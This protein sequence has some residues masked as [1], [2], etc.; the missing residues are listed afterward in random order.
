M[1]IRSRIGVM[2]RA[3]KVAIATAVVFLSV[4]I[5][6]VAQSQQQQAGDGALGLWSLQP[7]RQHAAPGVKDTSWP[8]TEID[9]FILE[10]LESAGLRPAADADRAVLVR[11]LY[12]DLTGLPPTP[13]QVEA[14]IADTSP[15]ALEKLADR[16]LD[17]PAFGEHWGRHW[18][19]VA[20]F[21]ESVGGGRTKVFD[22]AW[23]YRDYVIASFNSDK[24][25]DR[26]IAEQLAGDLLPYETLQQG[27][28]QLIA[29]T[30]LQ[31]GPKNL[32]DQN[33]EQLTMDVVDEQIDTIGQ[34]ML[35][36]TIGCAKCHDHKFDPISARDYYALAGIFT[37]T[38]SLNHANVSEYI[39]RPLP[40]DDET[41]AMWSLH[42][43]L[44]ELSK[45]QL[46]TEQAK[47][48][49]LGKQLAEV[50]QKLPGIEMDDEQAVRT[51][52]WSVSNTVK[53]FK[54]SGY[55]YSS[56]PTAEAKFQTVL[57]H[58]GRYEVWVSYTA[59]ENRAT[60]TRVVVEHAGGQSEQ[61]LNQRRPGTIGGR[62]ASLGV[63][64]FTADRAAAVAV[65]HGGANGI[66]VADA[67]RFIPM[68]PAVSAD[69]PESVFEV[70]EL[71]RLTELLG[72]S[73]T[74]LASLQKESEKIKKNTPPKPPHAMTVREADAP[75][76]TP[77]RLRGVEAGHGPLVPRGF[78]SAVPTAH[79]PSIPQ[80]HSGRLELAQWMTQPDHPLT[81]RVMVNR[82]WG[83]LLGQGLVRS[84]D[85][86][87]TRGETPTHP[88]L[89]DHLALRF[90][91]EGWSVKKMVR[92][93]VLSRVYQL[94][95]D[96]PDT[97]AATADPQNR[98]LWRAH[99]KRLGAEALRDAMLQTVG[100]LDRAMGGRTIE[101]KVESEFDYHL[102]HQS[103]RRGVY[104]PVFR[105]SLPGEF[106]VFD[107]AEPN[108]VCGMRNVSTL[109]TQ[110]L[111]M[112]NSPFVFERA[113]SAATH[114][115]QK[116]PATDHDRIHAVYQQTLSRPPTDREFKLTREFLEQQRAAGAGDIETWSAVYQTLFGCV[117]FRYLH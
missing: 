107:F 82:I 50:Q 69:D 88:E 99:P 103:H 20:R 46:T 92:R 63:F 24:P 111:F 108:L 22:E 106:E 41:V 52:N 12:Y 70:R 1:R 72:Q 33:K 37:S 101:G 25:Y 96:A 40:M 4:C 110:A 14:F 117:D 67:V 114:L 85:N 86:F 29:T 68:N 49:D 65:S 11:R 10:K 62:F 36:M 112:L 54:G 30:F 56:D 21:A 16:L 43:G 9:R 2:G 51:G 81:A 109:P 15:D 53:P 79:T 47:L 39:E 105:N 83:H 34:A 73:E 28:S 44:L 55:R 84:V 45:L 95:S 91:A 100:E 18:L 113:E 78:L 104:L 75:A 26:F 116:G 42:N 35:G 64:E 23:R 93:I 27:G 7:M 58:D 48:G 94:S 3:E 115:L 5:T 90:I 13:R 38:V 102:K 98:L 74:R 19:D 60:N 77:I 71:T 8:R 76:D 80:D 17:S 89:F 87:G 57:E 97:Q 66:V 32:D 61:K 31:L 59:H 6:W